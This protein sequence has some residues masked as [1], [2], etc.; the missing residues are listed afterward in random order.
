MATPLFKVEA[1]KTKYIIDSVITF[2]DKDNKDVD[3]PFKL[4][5]DDYHY[6]AD[7]MQKSD[8]EDKLE[9]LAN[10]FFKFPKGFKLHESVE[11]INVYMSVIEA[12]GKKLSKKKPSNRR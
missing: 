2:P 7:V 12:V 10:D 1:N 3:I 8:F 11:L 5:H 4:T 9:Y 6:S